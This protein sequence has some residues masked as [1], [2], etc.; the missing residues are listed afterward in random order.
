MKNEGMTS[1]VM[2]SLYILSL[3]DRES[4]TV[5][6]QVWFNATYTQLQESPVFIRFDIGRRFCFLGSFFPFIFPMAI[7]RTVFI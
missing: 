4:I 3:R 7:A 6:K 1:R 5:P 2:Y